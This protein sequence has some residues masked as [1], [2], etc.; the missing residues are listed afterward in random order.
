M[1]E[2]LLEKHF[3]QVNRAMVDQ[4]IDT[5]EVLLDKEM[6]LIHM[7]GYVQPKAEWLADIAS[8]QMSYFSS[9]HEKVENVKI[10]GNRAKMTSYDLVEASIWGSTRHTWRL[11][12]DVHFEKKDGDWKIVKQIASTF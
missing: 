11:K 9:T 10:E 6:S 8:G 1:T 2:Q 3:R 5:L 12:M 4:D 7:T